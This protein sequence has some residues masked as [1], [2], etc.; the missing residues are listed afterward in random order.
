MPP[1]SQ[2]LSHILQQHK[3]KSQCRIID[4]T[5]VQGGA[6]PRN[7]DLRGDRSLV[8]VDTPGA[9]GAHS[10]HCRHGDT[11]SVAAC[12]C[13]RYT[14]GKSQPEAPCL[15]PAAAVPHY[16][17]AMATCLETT[18]TRGDLG[19]GDSRLL[20]GRPGGKN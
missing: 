19:P 2:S 7:A 17:L 8:A 4:V 6:P 1:F 5:G 13:R 10:I 20:G 14:G 3:G 15:R 18:R 11:C 9:C 16:G 12:T